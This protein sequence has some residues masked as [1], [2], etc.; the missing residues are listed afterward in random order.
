M[1]MT[2]LGPVCGSKNGTLLSIW[3]LDHLP[4]ESHAK[5]VFTLAMQ[6]YTGKNRKARAIAPRLQPPSAVS[7][8][9][10]VLAS[11]RISR[12]VKYASS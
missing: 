9:R 12:T 6:T 10:T 2:V 4:C 7:S 11:A 1:S 8:G 3:N 5:A